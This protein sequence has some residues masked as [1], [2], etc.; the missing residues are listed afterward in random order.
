[1]ILLVIE[2]HRCFGPHNS[3]HIQHPLGLGGEIQTHP[4]E[5]GSLIL[6]ADDGDT[7][8]LF[9]KTSGAV[10]SG[11]SASGVTCHVAHAPGAAV[12]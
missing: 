12:R 1:M 6:V 5:Q 11:P 7:F 3:P 9:T 2:P 4:T 10:A 8:Y